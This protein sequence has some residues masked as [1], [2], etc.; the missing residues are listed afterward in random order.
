[1][2]MKELRLQTVGKVPTFLSFTHLFAGENCEEGGEF[3]R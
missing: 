1:M 2:E 3:H